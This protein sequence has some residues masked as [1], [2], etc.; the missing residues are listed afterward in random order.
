MQGCDELGEIPRN[1]L[2]I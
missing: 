1:T 2:P